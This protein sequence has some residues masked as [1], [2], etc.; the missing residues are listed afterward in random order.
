MSSTAENRLRV[1]REMGK[2]ISIFDL[3]DVDFTSRDRSSFFNSHVG[4]DG[5]VK[6]TSKELAN[7]KRLGN[8][9]RT[10][11]AGLVGAMTVACDFIE[12]TCME[13][14][15]TGGGKFCCHGDAQGGKCRDLG[16]HG[17]MRGK[18]KPTYCDLF[19]C[20][21][22]AENLKSTNPAAYDEWH[23]IL[24]EIG[25]DGLAMLMN[26]FGVEIRH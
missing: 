1:A 5:I 26:Q 18:R 15:M 20:D 13:E 17:C 7:A 14:R 8:Q 10:R 24:D 25:S 22:A 16:T 6:P 2:S 12:G 9:Y 4:G 23:N 19:L 3:G 21:A 11:L